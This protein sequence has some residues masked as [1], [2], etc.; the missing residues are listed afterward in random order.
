MKKVKNKIGKKILVLSLALLFI[1]GTAVTRVEAEDPCTKA[2]DKCLR[3]AVLTALLSGLTTF[4]LY[5]TFC[6]TGYVWCT[7]YYKG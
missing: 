5:F 6:S 1:L 3:D 4:S 2:L 7:R